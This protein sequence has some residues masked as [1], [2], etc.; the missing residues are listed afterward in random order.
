MRLSSPSLQPRIPWVYSIHLLQPQKEKTCYTEC[1]DF[2]VSMVDPWLRQV[3]NDKNKERSMQG[4]Y[5]GESN[6]REYQALQQSEHGSYNYL[7]ES[8]YKPPYHITERKKGFQQQREL[9]HHNNDMHSCDLVYR[10]TKYLSVGLSVVCSVILPPLMIYSG[11]T[12]FHC[13]NIFPSWLI[14][15]AI[16]WYIAIP[17]LFWN[18][19]ADSL[20]S[21]ASVTLV[22]VGLLAWSLSFWTFV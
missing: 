10:S 8:Q 7:E 12:F 9:E 19:N 16:L 6:E 11:V 3:I 5:C 4:S 21:F 22:F 2:K 20:A 17:L 18:A 14:I 15:G 1:E 13:D